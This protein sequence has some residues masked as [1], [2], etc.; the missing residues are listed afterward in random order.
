MMLRTHATDPRPHPRPPVRGFTLI[1]AMVTLAVAGV[2]A[3]VAIPSFVSLGQRFRLNSVSSSLGASLQW[4][5]SEAIKANVDV[6]VCASN[7]AGTNCT[8][9]TNWG[10]N[11]WLIC[12]DANADG[13]CDAS[14]AQL[15]NPVQFYGSVDRSTQVTGPAAGVRFT[16][17]GEQSVGA[18][19]AT[20]QA[21]GTWSGAPTLTTT[22]APSGVVKGSRL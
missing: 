21:M 1:E 5:R 14:T 19:T 17:S 10:V 6:I 9:S 2:L 20:I 12:Y 3:S 8:T 4:A 18:A 13:S 15:I 22:V 16:P 11:G 7:A